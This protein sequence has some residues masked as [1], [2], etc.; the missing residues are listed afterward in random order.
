LRQP[1][2]RGLDVRVFLC[3]CAGLTG[4]VLPAGSKLDDDGSCNGKLRYGK[5]CAS[6]AVVPEMQ[7]HDNTRGKV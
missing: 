2:K 5:S 6:S 7:M 1:E 4:T 3:T